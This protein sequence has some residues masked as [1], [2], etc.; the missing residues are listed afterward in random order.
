MSQRS[1]LWSLAAA[2]VTLLWLV[3]C[4]GVG[5]PSG[6]ESAEVAQTSTSS[7]LPAATPMEATEP[8]PAISPSPVRTGR[9]GPVIFSSDFDDTAGEP[10]DTG[11]AFEQGIVRL[12]AYWPY[13]DV[14][15]GERFRWDFYHDEAHFYGEY[16]TFD[17]ESGSQWQWIFETDGGPLGPGTYELVVKVGGQVVLQDTCEVREAPTPTP[18]KVPTPTQTAAPVPT[19]TPTVRPHPTPTSSPTT[20]ARPAVGWVEVINYCGSDMTFT[21]AGQMYTVG[22]NSSQR[23][24]LSPGEYTYTASLGLGRYG[25][26]NGS[27]T[28]EA[29]VISQLS[30]SAEV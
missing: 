17:F 7:P 9:F 3:A 21:I 14:E 13:E 19:S 8:T 30:F 29:G 26:I 22:A 24:E 28:V 15:P 16:G 6:S 12:Y 23:I 5:A 10:A 1:R 11:L 27:V 18:T 4:D 20:E 25:D 2:V